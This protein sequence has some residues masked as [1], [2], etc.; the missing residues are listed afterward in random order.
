MKIGNFTAMLAVAAGSTNAISIGNDDPEN[1]ILARFLAE[2][3]L[4]TH[5]GDQTFINLGLDDDNI[6]HEIVAIF[7]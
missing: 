6:Q 3:L 1:Y 7:R 2:E 5:A 4:Q